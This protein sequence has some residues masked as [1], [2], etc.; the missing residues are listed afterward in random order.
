MK[1]FKL[2][3]DLHLEFYHDRNKVFPYW[4]PTLNDQDKDTVLLLAGDI[5]VGIKAR[6]WITEMCE[7]FQDVVYIL[8]NHEFYRHELFKVQKQWQEMEGMPD[9]FHFLNNDVVYID[10]VR[11][12]GGTMWTKIYNHH[13]RWFI[14]QGMIDFQVIKVNN[15]GNYRRLNTADTDKEH[16]KTVNFFINEL[17]KEWKGKTIVMTHHLPHPL[18][19]TDRFKNNAY[20]PAYVT[21]LGYMFDMF[22]DVIDV[23]CHGHTHDN[24]DVHVGNTRILC[25]PR[26]YH[27]YEINPDFNEDLTFGI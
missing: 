1:K 22:N 8:G 24:V 27:G 5:H 12:L 23:W 25:N 10:N 26:G 19:V 4:K 11:I 13:D 9:N 20:T 18:C 6:E 2:L 16:Y 21:D 17:Q 14:Q 3:S 15:N 7:R